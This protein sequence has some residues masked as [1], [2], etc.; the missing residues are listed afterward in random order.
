MT[1]DVTRNVSATLNAASTFA[2]GDDNEFLVSGGL[3]YKF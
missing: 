3:N 1:F 2:R